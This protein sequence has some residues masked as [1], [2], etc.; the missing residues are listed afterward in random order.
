MSAPSGWGAAPEVGG[1]GLSGVGATARK[2]QGEILGK[3]GEGTYGVVY[4]LRCNDRKRSK[5]AVKTFKV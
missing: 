1:A 5:V 4:L 3:I 2:L